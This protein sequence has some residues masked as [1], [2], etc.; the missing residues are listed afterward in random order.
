MKS[1]HFISFLFLVLLI[2]I[3]TVHAAG[4]FYFMNESIN[5]NA[6]ENPFHQWRINPGAEVYTGRSYD[7]SGAIGT[8]DFIAHWSDW[9]KED[10][11]CSPDT[12]IPVRYVSSNGAIDPRN[13][14][15]NPSAFPT[16]NYFTW[17]GCRV[18]EIMV[19]NPDGSFTNMT[20]SGQAPNENRFAFT[21]KKPKV[22]F[23]I[24]FREPVPPPV[25]TPA[26]FV[27][28]K[29][30]QTTAPV[31]AAADPPQEPTKWWIQWWWLELICIGIVGYVVNDWFDIL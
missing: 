7:I 1:L 30:V 18:W 6:L 17:D 13:Y 14:Y 27:Q 21:V 15:I 2:G 24:P 12:I 9:K 23:P 4:T 19:K 5:Y 11:D 26:S 29:P 3:G 10:T 8:S 20:S 28:I 31:V 25:Y 16:G 22:S